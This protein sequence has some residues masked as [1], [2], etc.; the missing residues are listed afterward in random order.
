MTDIHIL[1]VE[2]DKKVIEDYELLIKTYNKEHEDVKVVPKIETNLKDGLEALK[3]QSYDGAIVDIMLSGDDRDGQGNQILKQIRKDLR[4]PVRI[5]TGFDHYIDEDLKRENIFWKIYVRAE[6]ETSRVLDEFVSIYKSGIL[7]ILGN[8]GKIEE[9]LKKIF[10]EHIADN[11][12][13]IVK[14]SSDTNSEKVFIRY[15]S[16]YFLEYMDINETGIEDI[17]TPPEFYIKPPVRKD[18]YTGDILKYNDEKLFIIL[19]PACDM[20]LRASKDNEKFRNAKK[21]LAAE[22]TH[23]K[24]LENINSKGENKGKFYESLSDK[25]T[26]ST[27]KNYMK[28]NKERYHFIPPYKDIP[29]GFIDFQ[30]LKS[31][32]EGEINENY[33]RIATVSNIFMRDI[34]ARFSRYYSRQGQPDMNI[35][36]ILEEMQREDQGRDG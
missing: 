23:W 25:D 13:E 34:I 19:T 30:S 33:K 32:E 24:K 28:N 15:I 26:K 14:Y 20:V 16:S 17:Y 11:F 18:L 27:F 31:L 5:I 35:E 1:I 9:Y 6:E 21:F 8:K 36:R 22:V 7:K 29:A 4:F 10:W 2:D 12:E 3:N